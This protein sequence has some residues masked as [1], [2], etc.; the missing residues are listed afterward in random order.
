MFGP[1]LFSF[2]ISSQPASGHR[3]AV[4]WFQCLGPRGKVPSGGKPLRP[5]WHITP[6][7][8]SSRSALSFL[9][10]LS[11][12]LLSAASFCFDC[13]LICHQL[14]H[15]SSPSTFSLLIF[16]LNNQP[17][18]STL[19]S[20]NPLNDT[21]CRYRTAYFVGLVENLAQTWL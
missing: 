21:H 5:C 20:C 18:C 13:A 8:I 19:L 4:M 9:L 12:L 10:H 3:R 16:C 14:L 7:I 11:F 15:L 2:T 1:T 6:P 17:F